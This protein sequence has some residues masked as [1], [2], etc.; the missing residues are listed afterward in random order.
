MWNETKER[1]RKIWEEVVKT[2]IMEMELTRRRHWT[3]LDGEK[4]YDAVV[5][6]RKRQMKKKK[7]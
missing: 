5:G 7:N 2:G 4:H 3:D 1:P 6:F